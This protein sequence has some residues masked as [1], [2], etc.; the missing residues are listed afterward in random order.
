MLNRINLIGNVFDY[1]DFKELCSWI[2]SYHLTINTYVTSSDFVKSEKDIDLKTA[3]N[4]YIICDEFTSI[5]AILDK[6]KP[7][8]INPK[9]IFPVT[10]EEEY[11][12]VSSE[13][14]K[15]SIS[16]YELK[17]VFNGQN[18][19][20]FEKHIF[21][22]KEDFLSLN[23]SKRNVFANQTINTNF[24]G[25]LIILPD[26]AVHANLNKPA[27]GTIHDTPYNILYKEMIEGESWMMVRKQSPCSSCIYQWLCPP[28]SNYELVINRNNLCHIIQK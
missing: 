23:L 14:E 24:F 17:P 8:Q 10:S 28:P 1:P 21:T 5:P 26:G 6:C 11:K 19:N 27:I 4:I 16:N 22:N 15:A 3:G 12:K 2:S 13:I 18:I 9:F 7:Q 20:F 25:K